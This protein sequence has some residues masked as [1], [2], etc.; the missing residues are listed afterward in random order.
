MGNKA[1]GGREKRNHLH[2]R[3]KLGQVEVEVGK[4]RLAHVVVSCVSVGHVE[5][6]AARLQPV[7]EAFG[8]ETSVKVLG[9]S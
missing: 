3:V 1:G 6:V 8:R 2:T 9:R 7:P 4:D 5:V